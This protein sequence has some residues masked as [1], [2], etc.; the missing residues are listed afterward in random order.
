MCFVGNGSLM[1]CKMMYPKHHRIAG[2]IVTCLPSKVALE[3]RSFC[4][5][6]QNCCQIDLQKKKKVTSL[7]MATQSACLG[8]ADQ[9]LWLVWHLV[10]ALGETSWCDTGGRGWQTV[11]GPWPVLPRH[12][13]LREKP[14]SPV[15]NLDSASSLA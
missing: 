6:W 10:T 12:Q 2:A 4:I 9:S 14:E 11:A 8:H 3:N 15:V 1:Q 13:S 5:I 7:G